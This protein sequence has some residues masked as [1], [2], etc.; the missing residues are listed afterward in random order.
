VI[1]AVK[2]HDRGTPGVDGDGITKIF[3]PF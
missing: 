3:R 1:I 2:G